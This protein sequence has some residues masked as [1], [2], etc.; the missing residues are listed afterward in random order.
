MVYLHSR[1]AYSYQW[2]FKNIL[3]GDFYKQHSYC[4]QFLNNENGSKINLLV[5]SHYYKV[6]PNGQFLD[7]KKISFSIFYK[8]KCEITVIVP[9]SMRFCTFLVLLLREF[10]YTFLS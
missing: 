3:F 4:I 8:L 7:L 9:I 10:F 6:F 1:K 2:K 5:N